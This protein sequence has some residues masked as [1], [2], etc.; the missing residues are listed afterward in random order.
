MKKRHYM[1]FTQIILSNY[2]Y[3]SAQALLQLTITYLEISILD[4]KI[5]LKKSNNG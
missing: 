4:R 3:Y 2:L 1:K 5:I